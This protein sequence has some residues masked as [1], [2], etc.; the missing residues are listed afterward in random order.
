MP[1]SDQFS[2]YNPSA[3]ARDL[4]MPT[5]EAAVAVIGACLLLGMVWFV[6]ASGH[7]AAS[8]NTAHT[9]AARPSAQPSLQSNGGPIPPPVS[10]GSEG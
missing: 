5:G 2:D 3:V 9:A 10:H 4:M 7:F 8:A 6:G 1:A